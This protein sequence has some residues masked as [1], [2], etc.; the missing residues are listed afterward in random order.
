MKKIIRFKIYRNMN[1]E[2][3]RSNTFILVESEHS[4]SIIVTDRIHQITSQVFQ[5]N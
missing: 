1:L 4:L 5:I 3:N 2:K